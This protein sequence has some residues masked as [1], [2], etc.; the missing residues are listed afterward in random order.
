MDNFSIPRPIVV[1]SSDLKN[2]PLGD[3]FASMDAP[4]QIIYI[5]CWVVLVLYIITTLLVFTQRSCV[6]SAASFLFAGVLWVD[7]TMF[8]AWFLLPSFA[9]HIRQLDMHTDSPIALLRVILASEAARDLCLMILG[10]FGSCLA[11]TNAASMLRSEGCEAIHPHE[12]GR[13]ARCS[14]KL[15]YRMCNSLG[16]GDSSVSLPTTNAT[17]MPPKQTASCLTCYDLYTGAYREAY[18]DQPIESHSEKHLSH[19]HYTSQTSRL[20][21]G[22]CVLDRIDHGLGYILNE[23]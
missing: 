9:R 7:L 19:S 14:I 4:D 2:N 11:V 1:A 5:G 12:H 15:V 16:L 10:W 18:R 17:S 22:H 3:Q 13:L 6:G 23:T 20:D 8:N 21:C